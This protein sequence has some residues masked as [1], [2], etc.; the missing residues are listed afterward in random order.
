M[1]KVN[2]RRGEAYSTKQHNYMKS[3]HVKINDFLK[4]AQHIRHRKMILNEVI[5]SLSTETPDIKLYEALEATLQKNCSMAANMQPYSNTLRVHFDIA[6]PPLTHSAQLI[7]LHK[8][9]ILGHL[10]GKDN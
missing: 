6:H 3:L 9:F 1:R 7:P 10:E 4:I 8:I 5:T 2:G